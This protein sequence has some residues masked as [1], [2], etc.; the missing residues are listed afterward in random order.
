VPTMRHIAME[1]RCFVLSACQYVTR[2][3]CPADYACPQA[4]GGAV[5]MRGG[6]MIVDPLGNVLAGP[7]YDGPCIHTAKLDM[8]QIARGKFD[9]DVAGHYA[10]PDV[11]ELRVNEAPQ[12][13]TVWF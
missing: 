11:F 12:N 13:P 1:G 7:S 4:E 3:D 10:R 8:A 5:L 9:L 6:S 2:G